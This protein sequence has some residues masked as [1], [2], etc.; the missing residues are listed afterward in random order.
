MIV[1]MTKLTIFHVWSYS[2]F[3]NCTFYQSLNAEN[4]SETENFAAPQLYISKY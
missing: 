4:I 3:F 1:N 2:L